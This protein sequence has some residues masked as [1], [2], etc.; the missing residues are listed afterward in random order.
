M[1]SAAKEN[2][3]LAKDIP[4]QVRAPPYMVSEGKLTKLIIVQRSIVAGYAIICRR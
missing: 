3:T 4:Y 2:S 1:G